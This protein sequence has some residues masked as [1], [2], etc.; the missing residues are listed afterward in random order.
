MK[1]LSKGGGKLLLALCEIVVGILLFADPSN[2]T[3]TIIRIVGVLLLISGVLAAIRY[4]VD[5]PVEAHLEQGLAKALCE[6][7][8]GAFCIFKTSWFIETLNPVI[9]MI[10]GAAVLFTGIIRVQW[11]VDMVR[12]KV[13]RWYVAG[14]GALVSVILG[15]VII[16]NPFASTEILWKFVAISLIVDAVLDIVTA[17]FARAIKEKIEEE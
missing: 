10:Y 11:T 4:F 1:N 5:S 17:V 14:I 15:V 9:T 8:I 3:G 16:M 2:F 7:L 6:L 13:G 12:M